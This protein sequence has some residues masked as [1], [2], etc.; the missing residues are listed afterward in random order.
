MSLIKPTTMKLMLITVLAI[1]LTLCL[2]SEDVSESGSLSDAGTNKNIETSFVDLMRTK[3]AAK[4]PDPTSV[5]DPKLKGEAKKLVRKYKKLIDGLQS[6]LKKISGS[7]RELLLK[8]LEFLQSMVDP[9]ANR[10]K[11]IQG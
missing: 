8:H 7:Q 1:G 4:K 10:I 6:K 2:A 11:N 9:N 5:S 3:R